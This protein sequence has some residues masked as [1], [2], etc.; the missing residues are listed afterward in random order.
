MDKASAVSYTAADTLPI[1]ILIH[2]DTRVAMETGKII[3]THIQLVL[4]NKCNL[5][6]PFCSYGAVD[7]KLE[8]TWG[9]LHSTLIDFANLGAE[10]VTITGGGEPT[11][12]PEFN[13]VVEDALDLNYKVGMITNGTM[14]GKVDPAGLNQMVWCRIS[15]S[16]HW[17]C[18]KYADGVKLARRGAPAPDWGMS[19][20][21]LNGGE[22]KPDNLIACVRLTLELDFVYVRVVSDLTHPENATHMD[23]VRRVLADAGVDDGIVIYQGRK[24]TTPGFKQ[25]WISLVKP[26]IGADGGVYPCCGVQYAEKEISFDTPASMR[27]GTIQ[28]IRRIWAQQKPFDGSQ[29]VRCHYHQYNVIWNQL[30]QGIN[31]AEFI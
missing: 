12:H 24:N 8:L 11:L 14:L 27:M 2:P 1:K 25:C 17:D 10:A 18:S 30:K 16:D 22:F 29:C 28:D 23:E 4:T 9:E 20:V 6:C 19:Y 21:V 3:P 26:Y 5:L 13:E 15:C 31:H 7:R